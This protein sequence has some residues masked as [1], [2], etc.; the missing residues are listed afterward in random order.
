MLKLRLLDNADGIAFLF[1][2]PAISPSLRWLELEIQKQKWQRKRE[3]GPFGAS[4]NFWKIHPCFVILC[5]ENSQQ[6]P[7]Q[8]RL[9][10]LTWHSSS[11]IQGHSIIL[12]SDASPTEGNY[13]TEE[14][15]SDS[16]IVQ[17]E[18]KY[19]HRAKMCFPE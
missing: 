5:N 3:S 11:M 7:S 2:L 6:F 9:P 14:A 10:F 19:W 15:P 4:Y 12:S 8:G 1:F 18:T 16:A 17:T 13:S